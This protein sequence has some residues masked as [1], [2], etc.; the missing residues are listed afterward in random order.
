MI[1]NKKN[2]AQSLIISAIIMFCFSTVYAQ[3]YQNNWSEPIL[4]F[5]GNG[6]IREPFITSDQMGTIHFF[7]SYHENDSMMIYYMQK[8]DN[9]WSHPMDIVAMSTARSPIAT[10]DK[11]GKIHLIWEGRENA[12]YYSNVSVD[13]A[14]S[15]GSWSLPRILD[16]SLQHATIVSDQ[17]GD[18]HIVYPK[19]D[20]H[21]PFY[22]VSVD[23]GASWSY[24]KS[25]SSTSKEI[26]TDFVRI[27]VTPNKIL[28][29]VWTELQPPNGWPPL[30]VYYS[31]SVDHGKNWTER[32]EIAPND[33]LEIAIVAYE[34][35]V[36]DLAWNGRGGISGRYH[37]RSI[38]AGETWS[39]TEAFIPQTMGGGS[40][41]PPGLAFDSLG[42]LHVIANVRPDDIDATVYTKFSG[43]NWSVPINLSKLAYKSVGGL[44]EESAVVVSEGNQLHVVFYFDEK[45]LYYT[46]TY[47]GAPQIAG[48]GFGI[49][50]ENDQLNTNKNTPEASFEQEQAVDTT[51][52]NNQ[53]DQNLIIENLFGLG[54][55]PVLALLCIVLA[56]RIIKKSIG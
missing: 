8:R 39:N 16:V 54:L 11:Y 12:L 31:R 9:I 23:G 37:K 45:Q 6:S 27:V 17:D 1:V 48:N 33:Y 14:L 47:T 49:I 35:K 28:H 36:I 43:S 22:I 38:D 53:V 51:N 15:A 34:D 24:P 18:L 4:L 20:G 40:T 46:T 55:L 5:E 25:I 29:V 3:Q 7:W 41:D 10:V 19:S 52:K 26:F 13:Q 42:T 2:C 50:S 44:N 30:G 32:L 56:V 21:G